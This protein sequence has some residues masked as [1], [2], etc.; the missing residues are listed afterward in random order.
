V[1]GFNFRAD[2]RSQLLWPA[3]VLVLGAALAGAGDEIT[4]ARRRNQA[5]KHELELARSPALYCIFDLDGRRIQLKSR[6]MVL[7]NWKVE[8]VHRWGDALPLGAAVLE[9]KSTLFPPKRTKIKPGAEEE[10]DTFELDALELKDMPSSFVFY[11]NGGIRVYV[12]PK[13]AKFISR[14]G[15]IGRLMAWYIWVPLKNLGHELRRKPFAAVDIALPGKGDAQALYWALADG[16]KA[17]FLH[18]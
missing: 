5:L 4:E 16:T 15:G 14:L 2:W 7:E 17:L 1:A 6:G 11:L 12:R 3:L 9:K 10:G 8:R 13:P 18:R